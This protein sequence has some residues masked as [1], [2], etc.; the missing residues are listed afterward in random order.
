MQAAPMEADTHVLH[1]LLAAQGRCWQVEPNARPASDTPT[2][3]PHLSTPW[4]LLL[5]LNPATH[6]LPP[7]KRHSLNR[8][9]VISVAP[10]SLSTLSMMAALLLT[11]R[12]GSTATRASSGICLKHSTICSSSSR[13]RAGCQHRHLLNAPRSAVHGAVT[14]A[15]GGGGGGASSRMRGCDKCLPEASCRTGIGSGSCCPE[16]LPPTAA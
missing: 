2:A 4:L 8:R 3:A 10:E 14:T 11:G 9:L 15:G 1:V 7:Q 12:K 5:P 13:T 16:P 6:P